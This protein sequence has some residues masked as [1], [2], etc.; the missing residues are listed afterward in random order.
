[1]KEFTLLD[2]FD[3]LDSESQYL[4]HKAKEA[5]ANA[6]A[7]YSKFF[8]GAALLLEDGSVVAGNNQENAAYPSCMC[9]ERVALYAASTLHHDL[10]ITKLAV[11]ARKSHGKELLPAAPCGSCRQVLLEYEV[12]QQKPFQIV[13]QDQDHHWV[14][15]A[16]AKSLLPFC[17]TIE[18]LAHHTH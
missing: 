13:M 11:V 8:V 2:N 10:K 16:S 3:L 9:A 18:N 1:M 6:Y 5:A 17:F 4:I 15:A 12:R 7:P 14:I